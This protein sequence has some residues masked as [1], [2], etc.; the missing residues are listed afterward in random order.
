MGVRS[1][2]ASLIL[3][4]VWCFTAPNQAQAQ[5]RSVVPEPPVGWTYGGPVAPAP[6]YVSR[7]VVTG[8]GAL[9]VVAIGQAS[10]PAGVAVGGTAVVLMDQIAYPKF[11][12]GGH[13]LRAHWMTNDFNSPPRLPQYRNF[14]PP[15]PAT[16]PP[17]SEPGELFGQQ[18][19][20]TDAMGTVRIYF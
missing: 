7:G 5:Q 12:P 20:S 10:L 1:F 16:H 8:A 2:L 3:V 6:A 9:G 18:Q 17:I 15:L 19:F 4:A 14:L 11:R 13:N